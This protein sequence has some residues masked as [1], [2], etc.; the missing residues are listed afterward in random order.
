MS[1]ANFALLLKH[2]VLP[3]R[4]RPPRPYQLNWIVT[5]R[6]NLRCNTCHIW[7]SPRAD[8]SLDEI[9]AFFSRSSHFSWVS[10]SGGEIFLRP[11]LAGI[12]ET[13]LSS[14][15]CLA[16]LHFPTNGFL[17]ERILAVTREV[18]AMRPPRLVI[19]VSVDGPPALHDALR[20]VPGSFERALETFVRLRELRG[21]RTVLGMTLSGR[22]LGVLGETLKAVRRAVPAATF[23]DLHLN[24]AQRSDHYYKNPDLVPPPREALAAELWAARRLRGLPRDLLGLVERRYLSLAVRYLATG[25][26]PV[27]C[28]ALVATCFLAADGTVYPC[29]TWD[30]PLG[31]LRETGYDLAAIWS[32]PAAVAAREAIARDSCPGCWTPCEAVPALAAHPLRLLLG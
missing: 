17:T 18:L 30:A 5:E 8:L 31:S 24:L 4:E 11:D 13:V 14:C 20:G 1:V 6:C 23:R 26:S 29:V 7:T 10:L 15:S 2:A 32:S 19:T 22:N 12:F 28:R 27:P 16:L 21:C 25:R 9:R 3:G